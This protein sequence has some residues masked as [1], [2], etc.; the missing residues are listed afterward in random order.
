MIPLQDVLERQ[1]YS[2]AELRKGGR[3]LWY[4]SPFREERTA[5]FAIDIQE[6]IWN[7][8]GE[9]GLNNQQCAGGKVIDYLMLFHQTDAKGA[10][11]KL[12]EIYGDTMPKKTLTNSPKVKSENP[13]KLIS[14]K[15]IFSPA[16]LQYLEARHIP[17]ELGQKYLKQVQYQHEGKGSKGFALGFKNRKGGYE[18]RNKFFKGLIGNRDISVIRGKQ[19]GLN[20]QL[21]EG[22]FDFLSLL[23][24]YNKVQP[25]SD[26]IVLN[27]SAMIGEAIKEVEHRNY[28]HAQTWFDNDEGGNH[29]NLKL[30]NAF[31]NS[32]LQIKTQNHKYEDFKDVSKM[33]ETLPIEDI[34]KRFELG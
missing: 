25:D 33:H 19:S 30:K 9:S 22:Y 31:E 4:I 16:L 2:P 12:N 27:G 24:I 5:S 28:S 23:C 34:Q 6:N 10:L 20:V 29:A 18:I 1:G 26:V 15:A 11:R 7:D 14:S 21:I 8:F 17:K 32:A 3:E 13:L